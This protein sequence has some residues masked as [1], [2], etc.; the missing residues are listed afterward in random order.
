MNTS[1]RLKRAVGYTQISPRKHLEDTSIEKQSDTRSLPIGRLVV[2]LMVFIAEMERNTL[3]KNVKLGMTQ[4]PEK[5]LGMVGLFSDMILLK[6]GT[7]NKSME[8]DIV[9]RI[10]SMYAEGKGL[11]A[12]ANYLNKFDYHTKRNRHFSIIG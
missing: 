7:Y 2:Q 3:S 10:F 11:K 9:K 5:V 1:N 8:A 6:K 12:I 4:R